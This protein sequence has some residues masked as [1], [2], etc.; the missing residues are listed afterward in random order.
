M[1]Q[2]LNELNEIDEFRL[3]EFENA[4]LY[5]EKM[6]THHD[7]KIEKRDFMVGN[8]VLLLNSRLRLFPGKLWSKCTGPFLITQV[9]PHGAV[10]ME[11]TEGIRFKVNRERI[12]IH[13]GHA[14]KANEMI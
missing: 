3:K 1:E 4:T 6:K 10:A 14:E 11:N 12:K 8:L 5:K 2:R 13:L 7:Q 9:F